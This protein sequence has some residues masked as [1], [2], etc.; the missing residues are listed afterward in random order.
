MS[1]WL[2]LS[3]AATNTLRLLGGLWLA[4]RPG[5]GAGRR[6]L[7]LA[8]PAG[9]LFAA[10]QGAGVPATGVLAAETL[11]LAG[12][13]WRR[14]RRAPELCLLFAFLYELGTGLWEFLASAGLAILFDSRRFLAAGCP[15]AAAGPWLVRLG[16]AVGAVWL[17][18]RPG[19]AGLERAA[20]ALAVLGLFGAVTLSEQ[21]VLPLDEDQVGTWVLLAMV[22]LFALLA[23]RLRRQR[24]M[25]A[26]IARLRQEQAEIW[27][28]DYRTLRR[29]YAD[30]AKLYHDLHNHIEA[31]YHCL[32]EGQ[33]AQAVQ[34]CEDLRTPVR[35]MARTV[36]TGDTAIDCLINSKLAL[37]GHTGVVLGLALAVTAASLAAL[38][39][40]DAYA[41]LAAAPHRL[42]AR[43]GRGRGS[44]FVYLARYL[45]ANKNYLV[46]TAGLCLLAFVLPRLFGAGAG[47]FPV[48][49]GILCLN[50]PLC[51][52]LSGDPDLEQAL[53]TLPGQAAR[54]GRGYCLFLFGV[55]TLVAGLYLAGWL[56]AG[57]QPGAAAL[58]PVFALQS[59]ILS[60][61][62]EWLRPLRGWKTESELW[63]HPR[64]YL[65]PLVMLLLGA[66]V[67]AWPPLSALLAAAL[68]VQCA[69]LLWL[70]GRQ[71]N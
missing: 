61:G 8:V 29:T 47:L 67:S 22:L 57:G 48:G 6:G 68:A 43:R 26:Q 5:G 51:T 59:A 56:L 52:L 12:L 13:T 63:H 65:V 66:G 71:K 32:V 23:V 14:L 39:T 31:I 60:V 24:E 3:Y 9:C 70:T 28:R 53:R 20:A 34:Y 58:V 50:T 4:G 19:R 37:A 21:T 18:R 49:L 36:W 44:V 33:V 55:N 15:E 35:N 40:A 46:N 38:R 11:L 17:L 10:L 45:A 27:E 42:P 30:Q 62:L 54:F 25:E 69:A 7:L 2:F 64:K 41:L 16:A 1:V